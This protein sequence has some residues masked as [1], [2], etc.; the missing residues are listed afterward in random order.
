MIRVALADDHTLVRKG[1]RALLEKWE[2]LEIVSEAENGRE[3]LEQVKNLSPDVLVMD[4]A[5][6]EL[7]GIDAT[8][9]IKQVNPGTRVV[10]LSM[11]AGPALVR[12]ALKAGVKGYVLKHA[13][14]E[15][16]VLAIRA[17]KRNEPFLSPQ[18]S[19]I[20][21]ED[22][23]AQRTETEEQNQLDLL[24]PREVEVLQLIAEG[25]TNQHIA[26]TMNLSIRT[27]ERHRA[28]LMTK[29]KIHEVASLT[30]F[31]IANNL[32]FIEE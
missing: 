20:L 28:N 8:E 19:E 14:T 21:L 12:R 5:M 15:E 11:H 30:R 31:A 1:I 26:H 22:Y 10:L 2:E 7:N 17:A 3:A 6:P 9:R 4:I 32:I 18:V 27:V 25:H 16:L 23:L 24:T 29:L 13:I